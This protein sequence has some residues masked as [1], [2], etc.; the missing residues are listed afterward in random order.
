MTTV[1]AVDTSSDE[2]SAALLTTDGELFV[3]SWRG[4]GTHSSRLVERIQGLLGHAELRLEDVGLLAVATGPG[5]FT[6]LRVGLAAITG[7]SLVSR[8]PAV[9]I[10]TLQAMAWAAAPRPTRIVAVRNGYRSDLYY[11][12][13][14]GEATPVA[15]PALVALEALR[16]V[17]GEPDPTFVGDGA[18]AASAAL[19]AAFPLAVLDPDPGPLAP[20]MARR[21]AEHAAAV[22]RGPLS[23]LYIRPVDIGVPRPR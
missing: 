4:T 13:F 12:I 18:S 16:S 14:D 1:L 9:G 8:A 22:R 11:Q 17:T 10:S 2:G 6:G 19:R 15:P 20:A 21:T 5:S 3:E 23:P 7:L